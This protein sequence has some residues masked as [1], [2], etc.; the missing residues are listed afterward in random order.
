MGGIDRP[1]IDDEKL[2]EILE[3]SMH[4]ELKYT[5]MNDFWQNIVC[6]TVINFIWAKTSIISKRAKAT[7]SWNPVCRSGYW[8]TT[9]FI[10]MIRDIPANCMCG[11]GWWMS[12]PIQNTL[13]NLRC[14]CYHESISNMLPK[15]KRK[16][17]MVCISGQSFLQRRHGRNWR[18]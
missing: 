9:C 7:N 15:Q 11:T 3:H 17:R 13:E 4:G 8:T 2:R 18:W 1:Y 6:R 12:R 10:R 14:G 16:I 5:L